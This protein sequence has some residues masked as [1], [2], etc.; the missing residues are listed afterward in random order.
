[1]RTGFRQMQPKALAQLGSAR[2]R[3]SPA[4]G[5]R[6]FPRW[7]APP[8]IMLPEP[9]EDLTSS[10]DT[11]EFRPAESPRRDTLELYLREI[12]GLSLYMIKAV[13]DGRGTKI[14]DLA[15]P[16]LLR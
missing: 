12:G 4:R 13:L 11:T 9:C 3:L 16:N 10:V 8:L 15:K 14:L 2:R 1:M 5:D 7:E 6:L